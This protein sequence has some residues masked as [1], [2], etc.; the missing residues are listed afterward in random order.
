MEFFD[1]WIEDDKDGSKRKKLN[2]WIS[3]F[4]PL[5]K[6]ITHGDEIVVKT[7]IQNGADVNVV[8]D[9]GNYNYSALLL[10]ADGDSPKI[11]KTLIDAGANINAKNGGGWT[12]L[13][14]AITKPEIVKVLVVAGANVNAKDKEGCTALMWA[15][16]RENAE[17]A[18]ALIRA[19]ADV[20]AK[21]ND[22]ETVL[23]RA[24]RLNL[25]PDVI[26]A[27]INAGADVNA[28]DDSVMTILDFARDEK[29]KVMIKAAGGRSNWH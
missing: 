18:K 28:S 7:L 17:V 1:G 27:L 20:N 9:D 24:V 10:A 21:D 15:V 4:P 12:A 2:A 29:V 23:E 11:V 13:M 6:A 26:A 14:I 16:M 19:G 5:M 3:L 22:G 25:K 8:V